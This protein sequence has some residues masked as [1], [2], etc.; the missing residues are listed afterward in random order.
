MKKVILVILVTCSA[1]ITQAQDSN[2]S[3]VTKHIQPK[4]MVIPRVPEGENMKTFYDTSTNTQIAIAKINESFQKRGANLRSFDAALKQLQ[5]NALLN[6]SEGNQ[7]DAK[8]MVLASSAADIYV[9]TKVI[10]VNHSNRGNAKSV[11]IIL[12]AYQTGTANSLADRTV[13]GPMF[14]T[15]DV[16][17]LTM[18]AMD[19]VSESFLN[20]LQL[21]FDDIVENGQ[22]AYVEFSLA[23]GSK[24]TFDSEIKGK[25]LS[26]IIDGWFEANAVKGVYNDQG[27]VGTKMIISDIRIPLKKKN[28][29]N[30]NY[31]GQTLFTDIYNFLKTEGISS[32]RTI[33]TNNKILITIL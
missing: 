16:G 9:E 13:A 5:E 20:L 11:T 23:P 3:G 21:K 15:D 6:K 14:Q 24:Y 31:T 17:F 25:L 7:E 19:T 32:K 26:D 30:A 10:V 33:G 22:S 4:I 12:D 2:N 29:P 28:N 1:F 18:K 8:S 27:V